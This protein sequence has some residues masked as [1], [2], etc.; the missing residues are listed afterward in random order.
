MTAS[1]LTPARERERQAAYLYSII[2]SAEESEDGGP[3]GDVQQ[4]FDDGIMYAAKAILKNWAGDTEWTALLPESADEI[5]R[6]SVEGSALPDRWEQ[7]VKAAVAWRERIVDPPNMWADR[8]DLT[9]IAAVDAL[10][11]EEG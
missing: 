4:A 7:V 5:T 11:A 3:D 8:E 10:E 9:L 1:D 2:Q 6:R